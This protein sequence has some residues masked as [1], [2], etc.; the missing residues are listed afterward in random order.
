[1]HK[2]IAMAFLVGFFTVL[3][4]VAFCIGKEH[5]KQQQHV[6]LTL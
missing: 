2:L 5:S 1:M 4:L 6:A 3:M